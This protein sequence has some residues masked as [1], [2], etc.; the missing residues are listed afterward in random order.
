MP[1]QEITLPLAARCRRCGFAVRAR[2]ALARV[3]D[4]AGGE[5]VADLV[6]AAELV[7]AHVLH[8]LT[9]RRVA[10][11]AVRAGHRAAGRDA[12]AVDALLGCIA[13]HAAAARDARCRRCRTGSSRRSRPRTGRRAH[14]VD[15]QLAWRCRRAA[16]SRSCS[17]RTSRRGRGR[18]TA[19]CTCSP[20]SVAD[21]GARRRP[22]RVCALPFIVGRAGHAEAGVVDAE[23]LRVALLARRARELAHDARRSA[24]AVVADAAV[25]Q[26]AFVDLAIAVIVD[27]VADL[28]AAAGAA[29]ALQAAVDALVDARGTR[30][31]PIVPHAEPTPGTSSSTV[32]SQSLSMPSQI[33]GARAG[34]ALAHEAAADAHEACRACTRRSSCHTAGQR[35]PG[36]RRSDRCSCRRCRCRSRATGRSRRRTGSCRRRRSSCRACTR[37]QQ[38]LRTR[39]RRRSGCR[40]RRRCSCRRGRCRP[41]RCRRSRRQTQTSEPPWHEQR[42]RACRRR[43]P[44]RTRRRRRGC[45]RRSSRRSR[46]RCRRRSR[47]SGPRCRCT[48]SCRRCRSCG[49]ACRR[50]CCCCR[51]PSRR[52][53]GCRRPRRCSCCRCRRTP[54]RSARSVLWQVSAPFLQTVV[55]AAQTPCFG[56]SSQSAAESHVHAAAGAE[57]GARFVDQAVAIVVDAVADLGRRNARRREAGNAHE[58]VLEVVVAAA[59]EI[60]EAEQERLG[61]GFRRIHQVVNEVAVVVEILVGEVDLAELA[62]ARAGAVAGQ[63]IVKSP[64]LSPAGLPSG[65]DQIERDEA[66]LVATRPSSPARSRP[67]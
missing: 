28:G 17:A 26:I 14:A 46:C 51:R 20:G 43:R 53:S 59:E 8:A 58:H 23:H 55:P 39:S 35:R 27:A 33:F 15:A 31:E 47:A 30:P 65:R 18:R 48:G 44:S 11:A 9:R 2:D 19:R 5:R 64:L 10:H 1:C 49:R 7:G 25:A 4:A 41:R 40:R 63:P 57:A 24:H 6:R 52:R 66:A 29:D 54:R 37:R 38:G 36:C 34:A 45:P 3:G 67:R 13:L 16:G 32:P 50:P 12:R 56:P 42:A 60:F 62:L 61:F 21:R 22:G